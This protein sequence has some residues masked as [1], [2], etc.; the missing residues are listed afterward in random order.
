MRCI[1][2]ERKVLES[3]SLDRQ[4]ERDTL[5]LTSAASTYLDNL[6]AVLCD[7]A[8]LFL[9]KLKVAR[10]IALALRYDVVYLCALLADG[11]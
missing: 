9:V 4:K 1:W 10:I 3:A 6:Q 7:M 5:L 2:A 11:R 8:E